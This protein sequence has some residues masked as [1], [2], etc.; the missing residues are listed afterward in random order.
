MTQHQIPGDIYWGK[1]YQAIL[2]DNVNYH[3]NGTGGNGVD[4]SA[5]SHR[6]QHGHGLG[7]LGC[8]CVG[9]CHCSSSSVHGI[10]LY[11]L[12]T[13]TVQPVINKIWT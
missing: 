8:G 11:F 10:M 4:G 5:C 6:R 7:G 12:C 3:S 9:H 2:Q 13:S 1:V